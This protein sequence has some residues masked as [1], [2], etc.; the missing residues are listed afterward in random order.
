VPLLFQQRKNSADVKCGNSAAVAGRRVNRRRIRN[1]V[2]GG[3][4][5]QQAD[6]PNGIFMFQS[7]LEKLEASPPG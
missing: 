2:D 4:K 5:E 6:Q 7:A 3:D 1:R